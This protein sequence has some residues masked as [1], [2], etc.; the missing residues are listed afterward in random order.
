MNAAAAADREVDEL[1]RLCTGNRLNATRRQHQ[2]TMIGVNQLSVVVAGLPGLNLGW[3]WPSRLVATA[4]EDR[5]SYSAIRA[6]H[7]SRR[8]RALKRGDRGRVLINAQ[9]AAALRLS[10]STRHCR[11]SG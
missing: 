9:T 3:R 8:P 10:K 7:C 2:H 11:R 6:L 4:A 5:L 1:A